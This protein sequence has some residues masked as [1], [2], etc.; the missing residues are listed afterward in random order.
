MTKPHLLI[1]I[2]AAA[3]FGAFAVPQNWVRFP[4]VGVGLSTG[5]AS[6]LS[7]YKQ[8]TEEKNK[9]SLVEGQMRSLFLAKHSLEKILFAKQEEI[10]KMTAFTTAS[11]STI[12]AEREEHINNLNNQI[13]EL[14]ILLDEQLAEIE[15]REQESIV[16]IQSKTD[17]YKRTVE[18]ELEEKRQGLGAIASDDEQW[19]QAEIERLTGELE[20]DKRIFLEKYQAKEEKLLDRVDFLEQE[21]GALQ[22]Q[23]RNYEAPQLPEGVEQDAI[24]SRRCIEILHKLGVTCDYRGSWLDS[25]YIYVRIRP[26]VGGLKQV[27]KWLDRLMIELSLAEKPQAELVPGAV[28]LFLRPRTFLSV[29]PDQIQKVPALQTG[30]PEVIEPEAIATLNASYLQDFVEPEVKHS[31]NGAISQLEIDWFNWLWNFH[32]PRPIRNQKAIIFKIWGKKSGDGAG[33]QTARGRLYRVAQILKIELR[34]KN[35]E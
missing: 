7:V 29:E 2:T 27:T 11:Q 1:G 31:I 32:E 23:L 22:W 4:L 16:R 25:N 13:E 20:E 24:A 35:D 8:E 21:I 6:I 19:L 9:L 3:T 18:L 15:A 33:Y 34:R 30:H 26:R 14:S 28:Q 12:T 17:E 10:D 5:I